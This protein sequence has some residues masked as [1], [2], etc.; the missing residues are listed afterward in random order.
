MRLLQKKSECPTQG[1]LVVILI[2]AMFFFTSSVSA[3]EAGSGFTEVKRF[4]AAEANQ[5]IAVDEKYFYAI[6]NAK[7]GKY[8]KNTG[9]QAAKWERSTEYPAIHF[10]GGVVVD[11]KLYIP[12]SNYPESPMTSSIEIFDTATLKPVATH[13]FGIML[14]SLTWIDRHDG[15]WWAVFANYSRVFGTNREPYGNSYW[16]VFVKMDDNWQVQQRW[17]FPEDMIQRSEPMSISGGSWGP[18]GLLYVSG[19]DHPEVYAL[20]IPK[21]GSVLE[22]VKTLPVNIAGQGI[23]WDRSTSNTLYGIVRKTK[24]VIVSQLR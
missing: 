11:G 1:F 12:H 23:A 22:R 5:G 21:M 6:D 8:D 3:S 20:K 10:D 9:V 14:G 15:A 24:E 16:T 17:I 4:K 19:H 13:S 18:D 2:V 7:I